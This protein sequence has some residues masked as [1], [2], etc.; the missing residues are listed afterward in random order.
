[1]I[2]PTWFLVT[3][4]IIVLGLVILNILSTVISREVFEEYLFPI[5]ILGVIS[6]ALSTCIAS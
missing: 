6:V 1:M 5:F 2:G 4:A 3:V